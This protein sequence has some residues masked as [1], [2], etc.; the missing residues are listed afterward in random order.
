[1]CIQAHTLRRIILILALLF[2]LPALAESQSS[3]LGRLN[4]GLGYSSTQ[5]Y[6][7]EINASMISK[8]GLVL[9]HSLEYSPRASFYL[10]LD[11]ELRFLEFTTPV[12]ATMIHDRTVTTTIR[13][14]LS[15]RLRAFEIGITGGMNQS[16]LV[17]GDPTLTSVSLQNVLQP[18]GGLRVGLN[19]K[20]TRGFYLRLDAAYTWDLPGLSDN[21]A[22]RVSRGTMLSTTVQLGWGRFRDRFRIIGGFS[23]HEVGTTLGSQR[24]MGFQIG[25]TLG[26]SIGLRSA[27][28]AQ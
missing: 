13:A 3:T 19:L 27:S 18:Q 8:P 5:T 26:D 22:L 17:G 6:D 12:G 15:W 16:A 2:P 11:S 24:A 1:M 28:E 4:V 10:G 14:S 21:S 25:I 20:Q 7:L 23:M 9:G